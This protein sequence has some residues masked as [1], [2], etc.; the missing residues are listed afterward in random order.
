MRRRIT[1]I[2][3]ILINI[4]FIGTGKSQG[5]QGKDNTLDQLFSK[6]SE[7]YFRFTIGSKEAIH[8][9][10]KIISIDNVKGDTV[11]G[12]ANRKEFSRF[13]E[14][15]YKYTLL[16][17]PGDL[18]HPVM[19]DKIDLKSR[20]NWDYY[21]T[22]SAYLDLLSQFKAAHPDICKID[23]IGVLASGRMLL[24]VKISDNV[25]EDEGEPE[26][27]YTSSIHGQ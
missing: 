24:A 23:T 27:L 1:F 2:L 22:Y 25:N 17:N 19:V 10:T 13:M 4:A 16:P 15:G 8:K 12:Y 6:K 14:L 18:I 3:L 7:V 9:I 5:F 20:Q 26:F 11:W 21:P